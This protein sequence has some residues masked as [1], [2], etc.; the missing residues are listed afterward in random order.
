MY[1][2][3]QISLLFFS[4]YFYDKNRETVCVCARTPGNMHPFKLQYL[5]SRNLFGV[6]KL[7]CIREGDEK[8]KETS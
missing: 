7:G 2:H 5:Q 6:L 1:I 8:A 3:P 4:V